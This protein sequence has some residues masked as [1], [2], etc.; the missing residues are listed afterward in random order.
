M[1]Q[2]FFRLNQQQFRNV[3]YKHKDGQESKA[4][5]SGKKGDSVQTAIEVD[6]IEPSPLV[7]PSVGQSDAP[8]LYAATTPF[9]RVPRH[10]EEHPGVNRIGLSA[11]DVYDGPQSNAP[12]P[13]VSLPA[14]HPGA[15][16][17]GV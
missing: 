10:D 3:K 9:D 7:S 15:F 16:L 2:L 4:V 11:A 5:E 14:A 1:K 8:A 6:S 12:S 17:T 13:T